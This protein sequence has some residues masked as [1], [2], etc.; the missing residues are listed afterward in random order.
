M[1]K[2]FKHKLENLI[3]VS[4]IVTI[5]YFEFEKN[6]KTE[7][8]SHDFWEFVYVD[9]ESIVCYADGVEIILNKGEILFHKPNEF[10]ILA[11]NGKNPPNVFIVSFVCKSEAMKFF[12]NKKISVAKNNAKYIYNILNEGRKT[13]DISFSDPNLKKMQLLSSP[14]LGGE[15][16]I[17]NYLEIFLINLLRSQTETEGTNNIFIREKEYAVKQISD[18]IY[19]LEKSVYTTLTID[20]ILKNTYYGRAYL[21]RLFKKETGYSIMEY[22]IKLKIDKAKDL[23]RDNQLSIREISDKLAFNEPNYFT[24]TF[25]RITGFTPSAYRRR[26]L[27]L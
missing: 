20:E 7:G 5:H 10:H 18:L 21:M 13:F 15:Q 14:S 26:T 9:K 23:L 25:K 22:F 24:K 6:F 8:E 19:L 2:Y 4:K 1:K 12:E 27:E 11:A 3:N 17:K 16:I